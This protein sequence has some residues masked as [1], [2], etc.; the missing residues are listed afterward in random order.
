MVCNA[1][2]RPSR[3]RVTDGDFHGKFSA[4]LTILR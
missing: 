1:A 3:A 2:D 4:M